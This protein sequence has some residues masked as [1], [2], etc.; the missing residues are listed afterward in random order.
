MPPRLRS[1]PAAQAASGSRAASAVPPPRT[2][3]R[4][5]TLAPTNI[6]VRY[7]PKRSRSPVLPSP[8]R[9]MLRSGITRGEGVRMTEQ[10]PNSFQYEHCDL[11]ADES[12][13]QWRARQLPK[14]RRAQVTGGVLA[15]LATLAPIVLSVRGSRPR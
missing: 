10:L 5:R 2:P 12:L 7:I 9:G 8:R 15:A 1:S 6:S 4:A 14:P 3:P 13:H 11:A